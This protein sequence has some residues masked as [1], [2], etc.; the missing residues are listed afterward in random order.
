MSTD[1]TWL[2]EFNGFDVPMG[3]VRTQ[4][5]MATIYP[6]SVTFPFQATYTWMLQFIDRCR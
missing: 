1:W 2:W 5:N 6:D 3:T 4:A